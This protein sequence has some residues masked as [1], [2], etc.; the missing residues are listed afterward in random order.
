[1]QLLPCSGVFPA[2]LDS[3]LTFGS[4]LS[5]LEGFSASNSENAGSGSQTPRMLP[6]SSQCR[7]NII[8]FVQALP[9]QILMLNP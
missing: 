2:G 6:T 5:L 4:L 9:S 1:M 8:S 7:E 3:G